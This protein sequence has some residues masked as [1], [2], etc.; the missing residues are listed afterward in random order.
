MKSL[1]IKYKSVIKF[2]LIFISVYIVLALLYKFY[3][4]FSNGSKFYPDYFTN[5]V[6]QQSKALLENF[7]YTIELKPHQNEPSL[8]IF[9]NNT[10]IA[11]IVEGCNVI[12]VIIL[13]VAFTFAFTGT[14]KTTLLYIL[15]GSVLIYCINLL[16]IT[17]L[18]IGLYNYPKYGDMLH[19]VIFPGIIYGTVFILWLIWVNRF[20]KLAKNA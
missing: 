10:Y 16:R 1:F 2:I 11:R 19:T 13:F 9:I 3:I 7:G 17:F 14:L 6:A 20:S 4:Q 8:K 15:S 12:S 18:V 5:K